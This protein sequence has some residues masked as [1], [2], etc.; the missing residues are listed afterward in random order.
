MPQ[1]VFPL[2]VSSGDSVI[3]VHS[4]DEMFELPDSILSD[5]TKQYYYELSQQINEEGNRVEPNNDFPLVPILIILFF[6]VM[7]IINRN[8]LAE[9]EEREESKKDKEHYLDYNTPSYQHYTG[10]SLE[11][12][13]AHMHSIC[14]KYNPFYQRLTGDRK[15]KFLNRLRSFL[16]YKDF[17]IVGATAYREMPIL[18]SAAA[19][20]ISFGLEE[21]LFP[22]FAGFVIHPE[23][24]IAYNPL[25]IL[26]GNVQGK[27]ITISWKHFLEEYQNPSD[28]KNVGL[29][30]MAHALQV[31]YL[32]ENHGYSKSFRDDFAYYD[33]IDDGVQAMEKSS[34]ARLFDDN[35]LR[36]SDEFWATSVELFFE[37]PVQLQRQYPDLYES[38]AI[39]L[40]Q[41]TVAIC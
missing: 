4:T 16:I 24:Y 27:L 10:A 28:G 31:Q 9:E 19:V 40:N 11:F 33:K 17:Y 1:T 21:Y 3:I 26:V 30:E 13:D 12:T 20:Q 22:H 7:V 41:D 32:F 23:E 34:S 6:I 36:N 25:R 38:I 2:T 14:E 39:V 5:Q 29:H 15:L 8:R 37:R 18:M 35:A